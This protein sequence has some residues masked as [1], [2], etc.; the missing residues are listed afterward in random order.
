MLIGRRT[1]FM[2]NVFD[3]C[4]VGSR[5]RIAVFIQSVMINVIKLLGFDG[6]RAARARTAMRTTA[7]AWLFFLVGLTLGACVFGQ[8]RFTIGGRNLIII[9][10]NFAESQET[11]TI[12]A[13]FDEGRLKGGFYARDFCEINIAAKL[14]F[15]SGLEVEFLDP[16]S[17]HH[18]NP[19]F[20]GMGRI[21]KHFVRH[22][23]LS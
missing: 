4:L 9:G 20:F 6:I 5:N 18:H 19:C 23:I 11:V 22:E 17:A 13:I 15:I 3:R 8:Q 14:F 7:A 10:M 21:D 1:V 16:V 2:R 12:P